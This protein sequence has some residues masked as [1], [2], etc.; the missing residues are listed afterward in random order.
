MKLTT[1]TKKEHILD[2]IY[3][4]WKDADKEFTA[5]PTDRYNYGR[6]TAMM[7]LLQMVKIYE[8]E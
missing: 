1:P 7:D 5:N 2:A 3:S 8:K 4:V 6:Y